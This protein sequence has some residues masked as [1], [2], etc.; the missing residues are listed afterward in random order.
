MKDA[1][2]EK[3]EQIGGEGEK[4]E[5]EKIDGAPET[6]PVVPAEGAEVKKPEE[7]ELNENLEIVSTDCIV[8]ASTSKFHGDAT[9]NGQFTS[10]EANAWFN[11]Q[12]VVQVG[13]T[14][15]HKLVLSMRRAGDIEKSLIAVQS[16]GDSKQVNDV[17]LAYHKGLN[18]IQYEDEEDNEYSDYLGLFA[19]DL[20]DAHVFK[21][22]PK[23]EE[24]EDEAVPAVEE[25]PEAEAAQAD[26]EAPAQAEGAAAPDAAPVAAV[27]EEVVEAPLPEL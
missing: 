22:N 5:G 1:V 26:R 7:A 25:K 10:D 12:Y 20:D 23:G 24:K 6:A 16:K 18:F 19:N 9:I 15:N 13:Q 2:V 8:F 14:V 27:V 17:V 3:I 4:K 11:Q 21:I